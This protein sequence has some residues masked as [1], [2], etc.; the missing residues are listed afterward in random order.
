MTLRTGCFLALLACSALACGS[1]DD[2]SAYVP[3]VT[4]T[5]PEAS[6]GPASTARL[7]RITTPDDVPVVQL[8]L[9]AED[10]TIVLDPEAGARTLRSRRT[11]A[12]RAYD[13]DGQTVAEV[14]FRDNGFK[15]RTPQGALLWKVKQYPD[16]RVK[17]SDNDENLNAYSLRPRPDDRVKV[18]REEAELG[19]VK[20]YP[21][22]GLIKVKDAS[23]TERFATPSDRLSAAYGV[24]LMDDADPLH[25][26]I[27]LAELLARGV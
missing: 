14:R 22:R 10:V 2:P 8:S 18:K 7:V 13:V 15:L 17:V 25:Q 23:E 24:L 12:G 19:K 9:L 3:A 5:A 1:P 16:G 6:E 26:Y 20:F 4:A 21:E 27:L 11:D